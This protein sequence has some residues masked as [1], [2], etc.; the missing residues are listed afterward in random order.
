M[1]R[2]S[3]PSRPAL[4][5]ARLVSLLVP[6]ALLLTSAAGRAA[7][8][9]PPEEN[10][11]RSNTEEVFRAAATLAGA[12]CQGGHGAAMVLGLLLRGDQVRL[13]RLEESDKALDLS[14]SLLRRVKDGSPIRVDDSAF[15]PEAY[16]EAVLKASFVTV[17]AFANS[18]I[19]DVNFADLMTE[20]ARWRG[21]V[22]HYE[23]RVYRIRRFDAPQMLEAKGI[24]DLYECWVF[25]PNEGL[26]HPVCLV[27][28]ELPPGVH[29][30][31]KLDVLAAFDAYFFK[32]YAY[33]AVGGKPGTLHL[34]P[35]FIGRSFV[36]EKPKPADQEGYDSGSKAILIGFLGL[37]LGTFGLAFGLHWWFH[38]GDRRARARIAEARAREYAEPQGP[39]LP[40]T[41]PSVN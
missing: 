29:V 19:D 7:D 30:G 14:P 31:E 41:T 16:C 21:K 12:G 11:F 10:V 35:L 4:R 39:D 32:K 15:E 1:R 26:N 36:V 2:M 17:G 38:R 33:E 24:K 8:E 5:P 25:G 6:V 20:P 37:V 3:Y 23:G 28:T 27:C 22:V 13:W 9:P 40:G 34:A 18:R